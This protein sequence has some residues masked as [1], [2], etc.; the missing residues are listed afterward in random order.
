MSDRGIPIGRIDTG[1]SGS[2]AGMLLLATPTLREPNFRRAI[3]LLAAHTPQDGAMGVII[4][5]PLGKTLADLAP[6]AE[7]GPLG[8]IPLYDGGPVE[9]DRVIFASWH[10]EV[11][12]RR[13]RM[14]FGIEK[15]FAEQSLIENPNLRI[16]G[17][18]GYSGWEKAQLEGELN[19]QTWAV[20][21]VDAHMLETLDGPAFWRAMIGKASPEMRLLAESPDEP[22]CN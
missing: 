9:K 4:N 16:R 21:K 7:H 3:V 17:F 12:H 22:E 6:G 13:L 14:H 19:A 1:E 15:E 2:L 18:L 5:R 11:A 20:S 8:A 10:W